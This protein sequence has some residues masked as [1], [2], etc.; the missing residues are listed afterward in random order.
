MVPGRWTFWI[1]CRNRHAVHCT[2]DQPGGQ[3]GT[4]DL[5]E[6]GVDGIQ[7]SLWGLLWVGQQEGDPMKISL[8]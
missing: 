3:K 8:A 6:W 5:G 2:R 1:I 7:R 4:P